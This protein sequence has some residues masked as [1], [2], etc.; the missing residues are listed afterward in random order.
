MIKITKSLKRFGLLLGTGINVFCVGHCIF[1]YGA[2]LTFLSGPS[3]LPTFNKYGDAD[4]VIT[5]KISKRSTASIKVGDIVISKSP[6][7][8]TNLVCKRVAATAGDHVRSSPEMLTHGC[9]KLF[10]VPRGHI[11]LLGDNPENSTDSRS[12][13]AVPIGLIHGKVCFKVWPIPDFGFVS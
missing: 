3:M 1:T 5:E 2:E 6:T 7:S 4:V 13:G 9:P 11:W 10:E 8:P 12:Y